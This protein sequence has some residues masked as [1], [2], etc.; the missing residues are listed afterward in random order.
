MLRNIA[1][2]YILPNRLQIVNLS[3][4]V[5]I[6]GSLTVGKRTAGRRDVVANVTRRCNVRGC[7]GI[8]ATFDNC[9][10]VEA[11]ADVATKLSRCLVTAGRRDGVGY[12]T[13]RYIIRGCI[14]VAAT[15]DD[16]LVFE[17]NLGTTIGGCLKDDAATG[18]GIIIGS[19]LDDDAAT[20]VGTTN[21][22]CLDDDAITDVGVTVD[23]D[24]R[25]D[26]A[27]CEDRHGVEAN[28]ENSRDDDAMGDAESDAT[29]DVDV[30]FNKAANESY[31]PSINGICL[32][33]N[34]FF[35]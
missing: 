4:F 15:I 29:G 7:I 24:F 31:L 16:C 9:L 21:G 10:V 35:K 14:G 20:C 6:S 11:T 19:C 8:E 23:G 32:K 22:G 5:T 3:G 26:E 34:F 13:G 17:A 27:T 28:I 18:V 1:Y 30:R 25:D 2:L 12:T 33:L